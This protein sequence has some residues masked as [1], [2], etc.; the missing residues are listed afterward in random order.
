MERVNMNSQLTES[1]LLF[2]ATWFDQLDDGCEVLFRVCECGNISRRDSQGL[3]LV[4]ERLAVV[5]DMI[6]A[7]LL[8]P[9]FCVRPRRRCDYLEAGKLLRQLNQNRPDATR[10]ADDEQ[11]IP[12]PFTFF[13]PKAVEEHFPCR[14]RG[15]GDPGGLGESE[16]RWFSTNNAFINN[17][18]LCIASRAR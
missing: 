9:R 11:R 10:A 18:K 4:V 5:N 8:D 14:N 3:H 17:L 7:H 2:V 6:G 12:C 1:A 13:E 15:E 16:G